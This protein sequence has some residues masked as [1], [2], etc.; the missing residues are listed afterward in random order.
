ML[1]NRV[2]LSKIGVDTAENEPIQVGTKCFESKPNGTQSQEGAGALR[3]RS[4]LCIVVRM[5]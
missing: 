5:S 4:E 3:D 1:K 2:L